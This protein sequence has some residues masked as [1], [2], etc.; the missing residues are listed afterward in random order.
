MRQ[1]TTWVRVLEST[2]LP[3]LLCQTSFS[4]SREKLQATKDFDLTSI[5]VYDYFA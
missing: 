1:L 2:F 3:C 5:W 4:M